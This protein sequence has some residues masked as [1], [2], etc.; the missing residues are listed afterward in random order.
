MR[1]QRYKHGSECSYTLGATL[2]YEMLKGTPEL[3]NRVFL[4]L[5]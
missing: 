5:R 2:T 3:V 1:I 4:A